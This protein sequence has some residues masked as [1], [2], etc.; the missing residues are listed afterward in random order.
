MGDISELHI[1]AVRISLKIK[2]I[3]NYSDNI[4]DNNLLAKKYLPVVF[5]I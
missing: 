2:L 1:C 3:I 4:N 5:I